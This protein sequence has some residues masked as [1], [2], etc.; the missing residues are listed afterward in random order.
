VR[1]LSLPALL[2]LLVL[3]LCPAAVGAE[4]PA[5]ELPAGISARRTA[6]RAGTR[7]STPDLIAVVWLCPR[8]RAANSADRFLPEQPPFD[9]LADIALLMTRVGLGKG[10]SWTPPRAGRCRSCGHRPAKD[11]KLQPVEAL[12]LRYLPE[13]G[14]DAVARGKVTRGRI[15]RLSWGK[16]NVAGDFDPAGVL[17]EDS[18]F[19]SAFGRV[20]AIRESWSKA[21]RACIRTGKPQITR[22]APGY[23]LTCRKSSPDADSD[24]RLKAALQLKLTAAGGKVSWRWLTLTDVTG[25]PLEKVIPTY[26]RWLPGQ[27]AQLEGGKY[28][29]AAV[30]DPGTYWQM[31]QREIAR[32][33]VKLERPGGAP[34]PHLRAG[35][36]RASLRAEGVLLKTVQAGLSFGEGQHQFVW[37][38]V[39]QLNKMKA[40]GESARDALRG[41][42]TAVGG[43]KFLEVREKP[44]AGA[45]PG[46]GKLLTRLN[47]FALAA[48]IDPRNRAAV[49]AA[50][51]GLIGLDLETGKLR[52]PS[53]EEERGADGS[54]AWLTRKLRP[55]GYFGK[56]GAA[57]LSEEWRGLDAAWSLDSVEHFRMLPLANAPAKTKLAKRYEKDLSRCIF[58]IRAAKGLNWE[59][60]QIR[61]AIGSDIASALTH[62]RLRRSLARFVKIPYKGIETS[63]WAPTT[64]IVLITRQPVTG[65]KRENLRR[66]AATMV[67]RSGLSAGHAID[68]EIRENLTAEPAGKFVKN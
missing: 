20:L 58:M 17:A 23:F 68:L 34:S 19:V 39:L 29:A 66:V 8:C 63:F 50:L 38:L 14:C 49:P 42:E 61:V 3:L 24:E 13:T 21:V 47:V 52:P 40:V 31:I 60:L 22:A 36:Y 7:P 51:R 65:R 62:P 35:D 28:R 67:R 33:G 44:A 57:V 53:L 12:L 25:S 4:R 16:L 46:S 26:R 54:R 11:F 10:G 30:V 55:K 48:S 59:G 37:P 64:N 41:Y 15:G 56:V 6:M 45:A 2:L 43:G 27:S 32:S 9:R 5:V 18:Q 1:Y